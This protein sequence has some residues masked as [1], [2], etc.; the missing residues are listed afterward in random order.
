MFQHKPRRFRR[1]SND[2]NRSLHGNGDMQ[3]R[4]RSNPFSNGQPRNN[5]RTTQSADKLFEKYNTLAKEALTSGDRT[6]SENYFQH[7]DHFMRIMEDKN[8]NQS[9]NQ[10]KVQANDKSVVNDKQLPENSA[11]N[12]EKTTEEKEENK[13]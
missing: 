12:Q 5:F 6:L 7:A 1:R 2:R 3:A 11:V 13:E 8:R 9:Q 10:S 4:L